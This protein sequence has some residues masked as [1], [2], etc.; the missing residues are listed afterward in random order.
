MYQYKHL[1]ISTC[2]CQFMSYSWQEIDGPWDLRTLSMNKSV[3]RIQKVWWSPKLIEEFVN[4]AW[5][6]EASLFDVSAVHIGMASACNGVSLTQQPVYSQAY[7]SRHARARAELNVK[8]LLFA[9]SSIQ[10]CL[11]CQSFKVIY[12]CSKIISLLA[13]EREDTSRLPEVMGMCEPYW[14][15][16]QF[17]QGLHSDVILLTT[18]VKTVFSETNICQILH[19]NF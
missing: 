15:I 5:W 8:S 3:F 19:S 12:T 14:A 7:G 17:Y 4:D 11:Y 18:D 1:W 2:I 6:C 10:L 16:N 9:M 13:S